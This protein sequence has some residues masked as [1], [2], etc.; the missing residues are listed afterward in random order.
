M[1]RRVILTIIV[2]DTPGHHLSGCY[3]TQPQAAAL[4]EF[5]RSLLNITTQASMFPKSASIKGVLRL[6]QKANILQ[7]IMKA[8]GGGLVGV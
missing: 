6:F 4:Q 5:C 2:C 8:H 7:T 3:L 1:P